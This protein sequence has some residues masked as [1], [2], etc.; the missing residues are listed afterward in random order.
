MEVS[1]EFRE[2]K[3]EH[4]RRRVALQPSLTLFLRRYGV[5]R[6]AQRLL[7]GRL[8]R[9]DDL[10][11]GNLDGTPMDLGTLTHAFTRIARKAGLL[12]VRFHDLRHTHATLM[13]MSGIHPKIVQERPGHASV[14]FTLDI[15]SHSVPGLQEAAAMRL[16][17][18]LRPKLAQTDD[19]G[20]RC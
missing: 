20:N 3:S 5:E 12:H 15:Y 1:A 11:F 2:P 16:D 17:E 9:E 14:A 8:L 18:V 10:V 4:S 19:V 7:L 6:E 13:L